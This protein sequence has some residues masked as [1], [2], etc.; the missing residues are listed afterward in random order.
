MRSVLLGAAVLAT[1]GACLPP[2]EQPT[3][4]KDLRIIGMRF[5][6]PELMLPDCAA[7]LTRAVPDGGPMDAGPMMIDPNLLR[8][9]LPIQL[10]TLIVDP[11]GAG[12]TLDYEL[13]AC[14]STGDRTC[15]N[16]GDFLVLDAGSTTAGELKQAVSLFAILPTDFRTPVKLVTLDDGTDGGTPFVSEVIAQDSFR[17]LG[18]IRIPVVI[19]VR[20]GEEQIFA[21][22][23]MVLNCRL[24]PDMQQNVTPILPGVLLDGAEWKE[25]EV[26]TVTGKGP[27]R[28]EPL[29][30]SALE[31]AY[32]VPSFSLS[33][34][35]LTESWK[36]A[37]FTESG[38]MSPY[39][40]GG[41]NVAGMSGP[42]GTRWRPDVT[43]TTE[44]DVKFYFVVR[45]GRGG[46]SWLVRTL[47]WKP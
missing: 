25:G 12:R 5:E 44:R 16:A 45:D 9:A 41:T 1:L 10:T 43:V 11:Q 46:Q 36:I 23:L 40:T 7:L 20:A 4:V 29:D 27:F 47:H 2:Q 13:R 38:E 18:G 28:V 42:K 30:Y 17:G 26:P 8:L 35:R 33:P 32:V 31:E 39:E 3:T 19:D 22:K 21:Q 24:F 37:W 34:I 6:P 14:A 15:S